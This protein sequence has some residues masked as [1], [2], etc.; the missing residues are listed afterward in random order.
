M[1]TDPTDPWKG[2]QP[3]E[4]TSDVSALRIDPSLQWGMFWAVDI[5]R[6]CL[7]I[8][9]HRKESRPPHRLPR[10]RGLQVETRSP[11]SGPHD[12]LIIRLVDREQREIFHRLCLDIIAATG[13]G[14]TEE[15][16]I[17]RFLARTW[18]WHRLLMGGRDGRLG[19]EEQK[20]LVGELGVLDNLLFPVIGVSE[21]VRCWTGPL[22]APKDFEIGWICIE[23]KARRGTA[24]SHVSVSSEHQLDSSGT[25]SLY[26]HVAEVAAASEDTPDAVTITEIAGGIRSKIAAQDP[27]TVDLFEERL[28]AVGFDWDDDYSDKRWLYGRE[29]LF[30]VRDGFPRITPA[31]FPGGVGNVRYSISLPDCEP[32]R[33]DTADLM[34]LISRGND[35]DQH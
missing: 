4:R 8:L 6:N 12:L 25:G 34:K 1:T 14:E 15:D 24:M 3:P 35:A 30:E 31:M 20:G 11:D 26:L 27:A 33:A 28:A 18:R 29:H 23:A 5:D 32:F 16:A 21:A 22:G 19:D 7:L 9:Q 17:A 10:L 2:I 13:L